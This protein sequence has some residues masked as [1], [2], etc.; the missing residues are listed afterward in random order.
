MNPF[1]VAGRAYSEVKTVIHGMQAGDP[2]R[3]GAEPTH[4]HDEFAVEIGQG[5]PQFG[6]APRS[7]HRRL[8]RLLRQGATRAGEGWEA[9]PDVT[10]W[11]DGAG[12]GVPDRPSVSP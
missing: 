8:S 9:D 5:A 7:D 10:V 1:R 6:D 11:G 4:P 3:L 12:Q 2:L